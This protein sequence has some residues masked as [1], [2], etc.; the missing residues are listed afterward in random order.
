MP[1]G[2][3]YRETVFGSAFRARSK[4]VLD[5]YKSMKTRAGEEMVPNVELRTKIPTFSL[6]E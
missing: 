6:L 5:K 4:G 2:S 3:F 1:N